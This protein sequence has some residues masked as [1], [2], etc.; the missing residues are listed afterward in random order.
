MTNPSEFEQPADLTDTVAH[1]LAEDLGNGDRNAALIEDGATVGAR[2]VAHEAMILAGVP[3]VDAVFAQLC[4]DVTIDWQYAD[5][6]RA[7]ARIV[8]VRSPDQ[9][10]Q[11]CR[12]NTQR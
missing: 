11:Y 7:A 9:H 8:C 4:D 10:K 5:G 3:W 6:D 2:I 12:Q 1:A